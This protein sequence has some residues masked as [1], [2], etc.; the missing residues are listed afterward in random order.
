MSDKDL[1]LII[2]IL[3][4]FALLLS[5]TVGKTPEPTRLNPIRTY[6]IQ[7]ETS[8]MGIIW[9]WDGTWAQIQ[10]IETYYTG[11]VAQPTLCSVGSYY[12]KTA[13]RMKDVVRGVSG[14]E[15]CAAVRLLLE[16]HN[17]YWTRQLLYIPAG[18]TYESLIDYPP[19]QDGIN[20]GLSAFYVKPDGQP[21]TSGYV[22]CA[23]YGDATTTGLRQQVSYKLESSDTDLVYSGWLPQRISEGV[24]HEFISHYI[25]SETTG[26]ITYWFDNALLF[27][28]TEIATKP[29]SALLR[30]GPYVGWRNYPCN[31][32]P[33]PQYIYWAEM[34]IR[35]DNNFGDT[36]PPEP[37]IPPPAPE[38]YYVN[39]Q[40][41]TG[42][43]TTPSPDT[44]TRLV[45]Q[46][47]SVVAS[48]NLDYEFGHLT[49]NGATVSSDTNYTITDGIKDVTEY[50]VAYFTYNPPVVPPPPIPP[51]TG[52]FSINIGT[53][54]GGTTDISGDQTYEFGE[55]AV[56]EIETIKNNY[57]FNYY[58]LN[59]A[60]WGSNQT[61]TLAG[62]VDTSYTLLP[63]FQYVAPPLP[64]EPFIPPS[65]NVGVLSRG[66]V[67]AFF[68]K[69]QTMKPLKLS[70]ILKMLG[71]GVRTGGGGG[72]PISYISDSSIYPATYP[73]RY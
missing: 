61:F 36:P 69:A 62:A 15:A 60:N 34:E 67:S 41:S 51:A 43:Q 31:Y 8:N 53:S 42:G 57:R 48:A 27:D 19:W 3:L 20:I 32:A 71:R 66:M 4:L 40:T 12:G 14:G 52:Y 9:K 49:R 2:I 17:E 54:P 72:S 56:V 47:F 38:N 64:H 70:H 13:L 63:V 10:A 26:R 46:S 30:D 24:W 11:H 55:T 73:H 65:Q 33:H 1:T 5:V 58:L 28:K 50:L 16:D 35:T 7:E 18:N 68:G 23:D 29:T 39:V 45:G 44:Y 22:G 37:P 25:I 59:N 21:W 6:S